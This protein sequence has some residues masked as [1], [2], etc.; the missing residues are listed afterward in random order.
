MELGWSLTITVHLCKWTMLAMLI[1]SLKKIKSIIKTFLHAII[2]VSRQ[3]VFIVNY[4][5]TFI[6]FCNKTE[7][8]TD[9][10]ELYRALDNLGPWL[11]EL[12]SEPKIGWYPS[13]RRQS[14]PH[15][16]LRLGPRNLWFVASIADFRGLGREDCRAPMERRESLEDWSVVMPHSPKC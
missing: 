1:L 14:R 4:F 15:P 2:K 6:L 10:K 5:S 3:T 8:Q 9:L 11:L 7:R 16:T 12:L 13:V